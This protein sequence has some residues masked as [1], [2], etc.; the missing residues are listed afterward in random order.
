MRF[1][2]ADI[3]SFQPSAS[4]HRQRIRYH[5]PL[6]A[7]AD[8]AKDSEITDVQIIYEPPQ[9]WSHHVIPL[10][11]DK[12]S[13]ELVNANIDNSMFTTIPR[14]ICS[15][16]EGSSVYAVCDAIACAYVASTTGTTAAMANRTRAYVTALRTVNAALDD[17]LQCRND[18]TLL[19]IWMFVV[20][21]VRVIHLWGIK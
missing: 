10:V 7:I 20:Y 5:D 14:I 17:P 4:H 1:R 19:A 13:V 6:R 12:F 21:E 11:L 9:V 3:S 8:P 16:Q 15:S 2:I 18:S